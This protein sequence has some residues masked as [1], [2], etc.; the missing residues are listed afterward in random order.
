MTRK[1]KF[2]SLSDSDRSLLEK[3]YKQGNSHIFRRK[4]QAILFSDKGQ[5][6]AEIARFYSV[7]TRT[8]YT[9]FNEWEKDGIQGLKLKP[10]R[11]RKPKL[12]SE[13]EAKVKE[14]VENNPRNISKLTADVQREFNLDSL[15]KKTLKRFLKNL[16]TDGNALENA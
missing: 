15:S 14:L 16:T 9:W 10:G 4:S 1:K 3:G 12:S 13:N 7:R 11:G 8:V 6:V 2:I 5:S